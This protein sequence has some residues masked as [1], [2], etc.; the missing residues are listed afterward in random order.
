M[1]NY[2]KI[3]SISLLILYFIPVAYAVY[4]L[5]DDNQESLYNRQT[6]WYYASYFIPLIIT[7]F[8]IRRIY[9]K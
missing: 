3:C 8:V 9:Y 1:T 5:K 2:L 6:L 4:H 7:F